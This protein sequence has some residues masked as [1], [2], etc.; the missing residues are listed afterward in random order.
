MDVLKL[1]AAASS[2]VEERVLEA[3]VVCAFTAPSPA[4]PGR[5]NQDSVLVWSVGEQVV[6]CVA[7]GAGGHPGGAE[8]SAEAVGALSEALAVA[9]TGEHLR[10]AILDGFE[11]A[12][13]RVRGLGLGAATT[14][15]VVEIGPG[16]LRSYHAGDSG[17]LV[18]GQRGRLKL[19]TVSHGPVAYGVEAGFLDEEAALIHHDLNVVNNLL[20]FEDLRIELGARR[21]LAP[22]DTVLVASDGLFDNLRQQEIVEEVRS[23]QLASVAGALVEKVG[24]RMGE[25]AHDLPGKP[26][27]LSLV[28]FRRRRGAARG[29]ARRR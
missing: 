20:G 11:A 8:A 22:L 18:T 25:V 24:A 13:R 3:G 5:R 23:G 21:P 15:A 7:D 26:D 17:V 16:W 6:I 12:N 29:R 19:V 4:E 1:V 9:P 14:L 28:L 10:G 27:D 2:E